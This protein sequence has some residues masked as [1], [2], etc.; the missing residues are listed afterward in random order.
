M[1]QGAGHR[2]ERLVRHSVGPLSLNGL[3]VGGVREL[4][5]AELREFK[6]GL[7]TQQ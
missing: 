7:G 1:F 6:A 3:P 4:H 2:V 5:G